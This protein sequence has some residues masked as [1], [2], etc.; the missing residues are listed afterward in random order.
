MKL[1]ESKKQQ[2]VVRPHTLCRR[3]LICKNR[4]RRFAVRI[5]RSHWGGV[6][7]LYFS[8]SSDGKAWTSTEVTHRNL[9]QIAR[10]VGEFLLNRKTDKA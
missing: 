9:Q 8:V 6:S 7:R 2:V 5:F 4:D 3:A 10:R 1:P